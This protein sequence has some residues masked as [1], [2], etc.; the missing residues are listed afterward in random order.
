MRV[1][2]VF[3][4]P[5]LLPT[6]RDA[7]EY[8]FPYKLIDE[9][10]VD[11]PE[12][13]SE[14]K[15]Y[16]IIVSITR[17]LDTMWKLSDSDREKVL[18]EYGKRHVEEKIKEGSLTDDEELWLSTGTH[19][20]K[21]PFDPSR[22]HFLES[23]VI[24]ILTRDE[25]MGFNYS[26]LQLAS[27]ITDRRDN[28]NAVFHQKYKE[29]LLLIDQERSLYE[30][31][32]EVHNKEEFAYRLISLGALASNYNVKRL[33]KI[34]DNKTKDLKSISLLE[35]YLK[36]IEGANLHCIKILRN[37]RTL[38]NGY[39]IH[40]DHLDKVLEAHSFF[41]ID[42][43]IKDYEQAWNMLLVNYSLVLDMLFDA[44][45]KDSLADTM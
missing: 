21:N 34:T 4:N 44:V 26:A 13:E 2:L 43:P 29:K 23:N 14:T 31:V 15:H 1:K 41:M 24:T 5:D 19:P 3:D 39:P 9:K 12:E 33:K 27:K 28:I 32:R 42:Y 40:G 8:L 6:S 17:T 25:P 45:R 38:R 7:I 16:K 20:K 36:K 18:Y 22:I 10:F 11:K 37:I 35:E 30:L